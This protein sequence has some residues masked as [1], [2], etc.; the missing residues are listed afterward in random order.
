MF[1]TF[2]NLLSGELFGIVIEPIFC[3]LNICFIAYKCLF[4]I[5]AF[6]VFLGILAF[7]KADKGEQCKST[8]CI[9]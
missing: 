9:T 4:G 8:L 7:Q 3:K 2:S 6:I 1:V 5:L